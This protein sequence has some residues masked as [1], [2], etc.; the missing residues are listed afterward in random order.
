[1]MCLSLLLIASSANA[2]V[3]TSTVGVDNGPTGALQ[4]DIDYR[5][6]W[7]WSHNYAPITDTILS[8]TLDIDIIDADDGSLDLVGDGLAIGSA[9]GNDNGVPGPWQ[10]IG[11]ADAVNTQFSLGPA[12]FPLLMDG[13]FEIDATNN[14]MIK[15]GS[16][17][18]ILTIETLD[19]VITT[20]PE[21]VTEEI[22]VPEP[23]SLA[24]FGIGLAG[25]GFI[26]RRR[27]A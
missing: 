21:E 17:R 5:G 14:S 6:D 7:S 3:V 11:H 22:D 2:L 12:F 10:V 1:M 4:P 18:A 9:T 13:I 26:R 23:A 25:I 24:L 8:A 19:S 16:N 27:A 15:W 20:I